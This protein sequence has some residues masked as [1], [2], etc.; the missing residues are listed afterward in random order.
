M[1]AWLNPIGAP[2]YLD[3]HHCYPDFPC[4]H[5]SPHLSMSLPS[6][7]PPNIL[8]H[9][10]HPSHM[11]SPHCCSHIHLDPSFQP[12]FLAICHALISPQLPQI[13]PKYGTNSV[14]RKEKSNAAQ[15]QPIFDPFSTM[16]QTHF[17]PRFWLNR[18]PPICFRAWK[19]TG[20][21]AVDPCKVLQHIH[22]LPL[23][24]SPKTCSQPI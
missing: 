7:T 18:T 9:P 21:E 19:I 1:G 23:L 16:S 24:L 10:S 6:L 15:M 12:S 3:H 2:K 8:I 20:E 13:Q 11:T 22:T 14:K 4:H 17:R 5:A